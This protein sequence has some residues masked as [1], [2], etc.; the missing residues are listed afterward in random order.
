MGSLLTVGYLGRQ[1]HKP[2]M[3]AVA[4]ILMSIAL[5]GRLLPHWVY[6]PGQDAL[7]LTKEYGD[8]AL[9]LSNSSGSLAQD[10]CSDSGSLGAP[11]IF[12]FTSSVLLGVSTSVYWTLGV[13]YLDDNTLKDKA[14]LAL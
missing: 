3:V 14:P 13:S 9:L 11:S 5:L 12:F 2:H 8:A 6:G 1:G 10:D 7:E 4:T